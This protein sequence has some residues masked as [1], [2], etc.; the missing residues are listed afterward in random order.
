MRFVALLVLFGVCF[1]GQLSRTKQLE[2]KNIDIEID[3][4][5]TTVNNIDTNNI[6]DGTI[7]SAD[8]ADGT[9]M[10]SDISSSAAISISK[11]GTGLSNAKKILFLDT[12]VSALSLSGSG[13]AGWTDVDLTTNT[14][15]ATCAVCV[16]LRVTDSGGGATFNIRPNGTSWAE[17]GVA[18]RVRTSA[19]DEYANDTLWVGTD[20]GQI[21]EYNLNASGANTASAQIYI[22]AYM[23]EV[24]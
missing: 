19:A 13:D 17:T 8:I 21:I 11:I 22:I 9:L 4:I 6:A 7:L 3:Q 12:P 1:A 15:S 24:T 10:D 14:S 5:V 2:D 16:Q 23:E 20:T 18:P